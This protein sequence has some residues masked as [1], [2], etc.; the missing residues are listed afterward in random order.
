MF[1]RIRTS[2]KRTDQQSEGLLQSWKEISAYL[3]RDERTARRWE[4]DENLPVRR[5][6][7]G[8]R[9]SVYAYAGELEA[10][11]AARKPKVDGSQYD[12][13]RVGRSLSITLTILSVLLIVWFFR[14]GSRSSHRDRLVSAD[15]L[16]LRQ[17]GSSNLELPHGL[18]RLSPDGRYISYVDWETGNLALRE[19]ATERTRLVTTTGSRE[20]P[21]V[22]ASKSV[23]SPNG[24]WIG[25]S[26]KDWSGFE[27]RLVGID[28]AGDRTLFKRKDDRIQPAS[29]SFDN[30]FL[31][32]WR[33][34]P[35][36]RTRQERRA[37]VLIDVLE[38]SARTLK[39]SRAFWSP[40]E[41]FGGRPG[42]HVSLSPDNRF[43]AFDYPPRSNSYRRD[44]AL[45]TS[46]GRTERTI[47]EH[48]ADDRML[49]WHPQGS[50]VLFLSDR[51]G[52]YDIFSVQVAD[53]KVESPPRL[54][55]QNVGRITPE[56]FSPDGAFLF[57]NCT[58]RST[59][60]I[61]PL[62]G[63]TEGKLRSQ[64]IRTLLGNNG[65]PSW[66]PDGRH[67][68]YVSVPDWS[69]E[70][71]L[72][73]QGLYVWEI[74]TG[75]KR[76]L[77]RKRMILMPRWSPDGQLILV[78]AE[79]DLVKVDTVSGDPT[80]LLKR[81]SRGW[82]GTAA[83][84]FADG[85]AIFYSDGRA[86]LMR[87]DLESGQKHILHEHVHPE[88]IVS[89][90]LSR[91]RQKAAFVSLGRDD[92]TARL[93]TLFLPSGEVQE[94]VRRRASKRSEIPISFPAWSPDG[95]QLYF[96]SVEGGTST[97]WRTSVEGD[98]ESLWHSEGHIS[99][100]SVHPGGKHLALCL[101][102]SRKVFWALDN[103][104]PEDRSE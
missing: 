4:K 69:D 45:I 103:Y 98:P 91:D 22:Y 35:K 15:G 60:K 32:A 27:I 55:K 89:P 84:W 73:Q 43:L 93:L 100:L 92:G 82:D 18:E 50:E 6:R 36:R 49:G 95:N 46:D 76:E 58:R 39:T 74:E 97:V 9:S 88:T 75:D 20:G 79:Q 87:R 25:Y 44:I 70:P 30:K 71:F 104:L 41:I 10:W 96:A 47:V 83:D 34:L 2:A 65:Q 29:W 31:I 3:G 24:K 1:G 19:V 40:N 85:R 86:H 72:Y 33:S 56:G 102:V 7:T 94:L 52:T 80:L 21:S 42:W 77:I 78:E 26:R 16:V 54:I 28:G 63:R 90:S 13:S 61:L 68:A 64:E 62:G 99:S 57:S 101:S 66:S 38:G 59:V 8:R 48:P 67:L 11:R 51:Q 14:D 17:V 37:I 81:G 5:Y 53:G 12:A 23:I